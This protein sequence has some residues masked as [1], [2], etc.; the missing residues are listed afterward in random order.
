MPNSAPGTQ[1]V[2]FDC[3][4]VDFRVGELRKQG[5]KIKLQD[6]PLQILAMLLEHPGEVV[7]RD[8]LRKRLWSDD[9]F[10]DFDHSLNKAINKLREALGDS[11][12]SPRFIETLARRGYRFMESTAAGI[13]EA[14]IAVL[15]F[16][17]LSVDPEN[18]LFADGIS[19][20]IITALMQVKKLHVAA[21]TSS[22]SFKG[23]YLDLRVIGEQLNVRTV[24]EGSVRKVG[25]H[26]RIT[27]QLVNAADGYHLWAERYDREMKDIFEIQEDIARSIARR[28]EV[29]LEGEFE[30]LVKGGTENLEAF[31]FYV[32]GRSLFFQRGPRL[33]RAL[34]CL[35]QAVAHD[36]NYALAWAA[37][38]DA[39]N[40]VGFYGL[41]RPEACLPQAKDAAIR[42]VTLGPSLSEAHHALALSYLFLDWDRSKTEQEFLHALDL[43]PRNAQARIWYGGFYLEWL[44]GRFEEG[45]SQVRRGVELDP[46]SGYARGMLFCMCVHVNLDEAVRAAHAAVQIEPD[47][48]LAHW[49]LLTALN[50]QG[51]FEEAVS[52]GE[53]A[54]AISGRFPWMLASLARTYREIGKS[55]DSKALYM[56]LHWRAQR[57]YVS[58]AVLGWAAS[59]AG[60][61]EEAIRY[62]REAHTMGDPVLIAAKYWP[63]Y[64]LL[65]ED[66]RFHEILRSRGWKI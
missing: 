28:L 17:S 40:M 64:A 32:K 38:A 27:A 47:H 12:D 20:E 39:Y 2:R 55:A 25:N 23:K 58:P 11:A 22:F 26:L 50:S 37:L 21:R 24:L 10:V 3:F 19:E 43:N 30:P 15:P 45:I 62:A 56:E 57:E 18:E 31:K 41:V 34:H 5:V 8:E 29:M 14:S 54:L 33:L 4:E 36:R 65:R 44:A 1:C 9:T 46:L 35:K 6:Q 66:P 48:M 51:R 60:E 49:A 59:A 13:L 63:D 61:Q 53:A 42:A 16:L 52:A 7:S